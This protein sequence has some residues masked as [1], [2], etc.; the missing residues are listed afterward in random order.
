MRS[1]VSVDLEDQS[2]A[3]TSSQIAAHEQPLPTYAVHQRKGQECEYEHDHVDDE[4]HAGHVCIG[5]AEIVGVNLYHVDTSQPMHPS[6][7]S[8]SQYC[9]P[10]FELEKYL[11]G[12][13]S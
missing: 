1:V 10:V 7:N 9:T 12:Q 5:V 11:I 13:L 4:P 8:H 2:I 6:D 3:E